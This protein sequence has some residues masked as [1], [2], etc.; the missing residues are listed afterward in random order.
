M[1]YAKLPVEIEAWPVS[2]LLENAKRNWLGL[3]LSIRNAYDKGDVLF[4][5][6]GMNIRTLEGI[7]SATYTD[8]V[9]EGVKGELYP[10]KIDIFQATY[11]SLG[12]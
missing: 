10:C 12:D 6:D 2:E 11:R 3:P 9:I 5:N 1:K 8:M 4:V 7:M